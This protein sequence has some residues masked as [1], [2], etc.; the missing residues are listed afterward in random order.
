MGVCQYCGE[1]AGWFR[2][3]HPVCVAKADRMGKTVRQFAFDE[4]LLAKSYEELSTEIQ[5]VLNDNK[6]KAKFV[7][8]ALL[9]G[10]N[11]GA[12]QIALQSPIT[13]EEFN[14]LVKLLQGFGIWEYHSE[15]A[16]RRWFG[17]KQL[18]LS[19]TLWKVLH[20]EKPPFEDTVAFNLR[21]SETPIFQT[22][23]C[24]TFAEE[25]TVHPRSF[26]GLS[27]PVGMGMYYHVGSTQGHQERASSLLP[28]DG[29][30][31][32]ITTHSLYFGGQQKTFRVP[33]DTVRYQPYVDAVGICESHGV[34]KVFIFD[35]RGMDVGWF[36]YNLLSA[37]TGNLNPSN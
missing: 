24:V 18:G 30:K 34:Q 15:Y 4:T 19:N 28:V 8:E 17:L 13:D 3:S 36:F 31:I 23:S 22:G 35:D 2:S 1:K 25:R 32:L 33:L 10:I 5:Q 7:R 11:D 12:S 6:V 27:I 16:S 26:V 29:G 37:I 20:Q 9:Q 21:S 14:R